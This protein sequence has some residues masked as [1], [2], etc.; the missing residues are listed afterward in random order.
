MANTI[1]SVLEISVVGKGAAMLNS[2]LGGAMAAGGHG[3]GA[4]AGAPVLAA[5]AAYGAAKYGA[6][7]ALDAL[8]FVSNKL[9]SSFGKLN[10]I[11]GK[12]VNPNSVFSSMAHMFTMSGLLGTASTISRRAFFSNAVGTNP[13]D[14]LRLRATY[15]RF[16]D[17]AAQLGA[18][19]GE[20][21]APYSLPFAVAGMSQGQA[22]GMSTEDLMVKMT[23]V[24]R[25]YA[26]SPQWGANKMTLEATGLS[27]IFNVEDMLRLKNIQ[28][29]EYETVKKF[30]EEMK[31]VTKLFDRKAWQQFDME[32]KLG[33]AKIETI[34]QNKAVRL[35]D[36][37]T[38]A[39]KAVFEKFSQG[40]GGQLLDRAI[41][42]VSMLI[43][44]FADALR[45][46]NWDEFFGTLKGDAET[47][48]KFI[49]DQAKIAW[50]YVHEWA[51]KNFPEATKDF[52]EFMKKASDFAADLYE[53]RPTF[54]ELRYIVDETYQA[55]QKLAT[56]LADIG[57]I[58]AASAPSTGSDIWSPL[59]TGGWGNK[60][61]ELINKY[62]GQ[63][64]L[65]PE[66]VW[67]VMQAESS[68][69][70]TA[71]SP[72]GAKGLMQTMPAAHARFGHP[73]ANLFNPEES[74]YTGTKQLAFLRQR[75]GMDLD[76]ILAGYNA[77]EGAVDKYGGV[78]PF[79]ETQ[80]Y[81]A[82]VKGLMSG[83]RGANL[84]ALKEKASDAA[85]KELRE[86]HEQMEQRRG[87]REKTSY[88][89]PGT[90]GQIR[91]SINN[92][93]SSDFSLQ[94]MLMGGSVFS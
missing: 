83:D 6:P 92:N 90:H 37:V 68:G 85:A 21:A 26:R 3:A 33:M 50:N 20:Q 59:K 1:H 25:R 27:E 13:N 61:N 58:D 8:Q 12:I 4:V 42:H 32:R 46:G 81:V 9:T 78:P 74:L 84:R 47:V 93:S 48:G 75:Y 52:D 72:K 31:E 88:N 63:T 14:I 51:S 73:G 29:D 77:G 82:K 65:P 10:E 79:K 86:F 39:I 53:L 23:D 38:N 19:A 49:A 11:A 35:L 34:L 22:R 67:A 91:L 76:K 56:Y 16:G 18:L 17:P 5:G 57:V 70:A 94:T 66:L 30:N 64:G 36:P 60:Y 80:E 89:L 45:S 43:N 87:L 41:G 71:V 62:A 44:Q 40:P 24:A 54:S 28:D 69:S 7:V 55:F 15:G 2:A